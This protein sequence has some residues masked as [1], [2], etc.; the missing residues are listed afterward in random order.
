[1]KVLQVFVVREALC[2]VLESFYFVSWVGQS[3]GRDI[4]ISWTSSA[5]YTIHEPRLHWYLLAKVE[6]V[7]WVPH[8]QGQ[9]RV[10]VKGLTVTSGSCSRLLRSLVLSSSEAAVAKGFKHVRRILS[11]CLLLVA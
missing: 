10:G 1:M 7:T 4:S 11:N 9:L 2:F 5:S 8:G 6:V 3:R